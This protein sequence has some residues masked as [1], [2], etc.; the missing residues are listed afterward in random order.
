MKHALGD[1]AMKSRMRFL[2]TG[3]MGVLALG[4][5]IPQDSVPQD[6]VLQERQATEVDTPMAVEMKLLEE[7]MKLL[8]R[9]V[10][11]PSKHA[12]A[13]ELVVSMQAASLKCKTLIPVMAANIAETNRTKFVDEYRM[14]MAVFL[15][16]LLELEITLL[17]GDSEKAYLLYQELDDLKNKGHEQF[18]Q[19]G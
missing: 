7:G 11:D 14:Q 8:R 12:A 13:L 16:R 9:Q 18:V 17:K 19:E 3:L 15:Q 10:K 6:S 2:A 4:I 1:Y 5:A